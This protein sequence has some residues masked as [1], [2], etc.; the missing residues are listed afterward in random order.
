[1]KNQ[2]EIVF[3]EQQTRTHDRVTVKQCSNSLLLLFLWKNSTQTN[4][5]TQNKQLKQQQ[6]LCIFTSQEKTSRTLLNIVCK[7]AE[8]SGVKP[9][10]LRE[11]TEPTVRCES[12]PTVVARSSRKRSSRDSRPGR[13]GFFSGPTR[14]A[15]RAR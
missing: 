11:R 2:K 3:N 13:T 8:C 10:L 7:L 4:R 5:D 14:R 9:A 6:N 12:S 15:P 1:M